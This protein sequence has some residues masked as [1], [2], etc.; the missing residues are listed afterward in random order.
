MRKVI[1]ETESV[2]P[3]MSYPLV[4]DVVG[5]FCT[6]VFLSISNSRKSNSASRAS[7]STSRSSEVTTH[8]LTRSQVQR[9]A[10][11]L[12]SAVKTLPQGPQECHL[13]QLNISNM[14]EDP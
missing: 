7:R 6:G 13:A 3:V 2:S 4:P 11:A 10:L 5:S 1:K 12:A 14:M 8:F 9:E